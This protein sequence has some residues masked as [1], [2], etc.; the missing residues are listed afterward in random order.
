MPFSVRNQVLEIILKK[1][2]STESICKAQPR[3][4]N[5]IR[6]KDALLYQIPGLPKRNPVRNNALGKSLL[7]F[8]NQKQPA[9]PKRPRIW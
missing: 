3:I 8:D 6:L 1:S 4:I 2:V 7:F 9:A 5:T